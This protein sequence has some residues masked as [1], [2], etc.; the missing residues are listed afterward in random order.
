[1][2]KIK[3]IFKKTVYIYI[4]IYIYMCMTSSLFCTAEIDTTL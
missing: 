2:E 3:I 4:Y 1:M